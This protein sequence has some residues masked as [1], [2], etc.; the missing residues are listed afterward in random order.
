QLQ[1]KTALIL[2]GSKGIG[3]GIAD[4]LAAEGVAVAMLA[5]T[6][7]TLDKS[8]AEIN[9]RGGRAIGIA[10][11]LADWPSVERAANSAR[12]QLGAIDILVNNSGGPPPSGVSGVGPELWQAQFNSMVL[13]LFRIT[14]LLLPD[15]RARKWGRILNVASLSVIEPIVGLGVSNTLRSAIVGWAKTLAGE[16]AR[17]GIT[18]NT[19]LPGL[20]ATDRSLQLSRAFAERQ[21]IT[22]DEALKRSAAT[23]PVGR[24]GT[25]AEFGAVAAFLASPLASYV[26]GSLIRIDG[27][28]IRSV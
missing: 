19:L 1:N 27:G 15:M 12:Q 9:A 17:D 25:P 28:S 23:I 2:G 22:M 10:A 7:A 11:D 5:R 8:A 26:T 14:D 24:L 4:A 16:V 21:N 3:R 18:V 6:Q 13:A 20:I